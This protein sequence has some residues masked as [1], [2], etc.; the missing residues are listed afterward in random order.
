VP[1]FS[2]Q[3]FF[4]FFDLGS[5]LPEQGEAFH[6]IEGTSERD[7]I[8]NFVLAWSIHASGCKASLTFEVRIHISSS[9]HVFCITLR[10]ISCIFPFFKIG[11]PS[12]SVSAFYSDLFR[13]PTQVDIT[14]S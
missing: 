12:S 1:A 4:T 8:T 6:I 3:H 11:F 9:R 10:S 2:N 5:N 13:N 14:G 7:F